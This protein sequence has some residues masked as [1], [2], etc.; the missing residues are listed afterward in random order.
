MGRAIL[1]SLLLLG[2][3]ACLVPGTRSSIMAV[4]L[5]SEFMK[6][7]LVQPGRTPISI[8]INE[9]SKR[10]TPAL[11]GFVGR[12]RLVGEEAAGLA[13]RH[14]TAFVANLPALLGR[15][16]D[17]LALAALAAQGLPLPRLV[18][19]AN[20]TGALALDFGEAG[21][22]TP[23]ELAASLLQYAA[24]IA[25]AASATGTAP[26]DLVLLAPAHYGPRR[27]QA[28]LDAAAA[29]GLNVLG[30]VS[31]AAAAALQYGIDR[32]ATFASGGPQ[33]VLLYDLGSGGLEV[34]LVRFST[35]PDRKVSGF[36]GAPAS[37]VE[38]M[39]VAW[40]EGA[41][42]QLL[43]SLLLR[44][45][46]AQAGEA[47]GEAGADL[48]ASPRAVAKLRAGVKRALRVLSAN[49]EAPLSV[50]E[51]HAGRDFRSSISREALERL[52]G[53]YWARVT[54]PALDLLARNGV[55][56]ADLAAVELLGGGS[57]IP[58]VKAELSQALGGRALD[59]HLDADEAVVLGA[60]LVAAN[61]ST[62]FRVRPFGLVD[63]VPYG[64]SYALDDDTEVKPLVPAMKRVPSR[65]AV[66]LLAQAAEGRDAVG[67]RLFL[68][69]PASEGQ[70]REL[71]AWRVEGLRAAL[72]AHDNVTR[73]AFHARVDDG[74]CFHVDGAD[75]TVSR[76]EYAAVLSGGDTSGTLAGAPDSNATTAGEGVIDA[77]SAGT[78]SA[79][80]T[81]TRVPRVRTSRLS[82]NVTG[83][84]AHPG[85]TP[86]QLAGSR[87]VLARLAAR[88]TAKRA[89]AQAKNDLEAYVLE[90][91]S[92]S[93]EDEDVKAVARAGELAT[94]GQALE[95]AE[96]W[97]Y[98][99]GDAAGSEEYV[100]KLEALKA[101]GDGLRTRGRERSARPQAVAEA[102]NMLEVLSPIV[103][104]WAAAKPW[105]PEYE[106]GL[107][108][109]K[110]AELQKW[111]TQVEAVQAKKKATDEPAF[112]SA[113]VNLR[114][115]VAAESVSMLDR[116]PAP[117][118]P[119]PTT[120]ATAD[121]AKKKAAK[122]GTGTNGKAKPSQGPGEPE[123][124]V[125][126][127]EE[128]AEGMETVKT[129]L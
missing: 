35:Y 3:L 128:P 30:L 5:G 80:G 125:Q 21:Q 89:A 2:C 10:K 92:W 66:N 7:A 114:L 111:L 13:T 18:P 96:D 102:R 74:G 61:R 75:F 127:P 53:D 77:T 4:D 71:G 124:E 36:R 94:L 42:T 115:K 91:A 56:A 93:A 98:G 90:A 101:L 70:A 9:I 58:R 23:E 28:L 43:E 38:I 48:A 39:D 86:E 17:D 73:V 41:G 108:K 25:R 122:K 15:S 37:Q 118:T 54:R 97:L 106:V 112:T 63:K 123:A 109:E 69:G 84:L 117:P 51:L 82:L 88:D 8:V 121:G 27:R 87:A 60:G 11:V 55:A 12:D 14:P 16:P 85:L 76:L 22:V 105:L 20:R 120:D 50:E 62:Q 95:E 79:N 67:L 126:A 107:A 52:A 72:A 64:V 119:K 68:S 100:A 47:L 29:A 44:H 24:G 110:L 113:E 103:E 83:G 31:P 40:D 65:R 32:T 46:M 49:L 116:R 104:G 1:P 34:A 59:V 33:H 26:R 99:E 45:F 81:L 57:R 78:S 19:A 6:V 129:E